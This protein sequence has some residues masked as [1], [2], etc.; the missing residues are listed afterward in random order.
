L[1]QH[2]CSMFGGVGLH[3]TTS[4]RTDPQHGVRHD[5]PW[6]VFRCSAPRPPHRAGQPLTPQ[7]PPIV[8]QWP[9]QHRDDSEVLHPSLKQFQWWGPSQDRGNPSPASVSPQLL[10]ANC[11][12]FT[13]AGN[14][15]ARSVECR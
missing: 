8:L 13:W 2:T 3:S 15:E 4:P 12:S 10:F 14:G 11:S 1:L 5:P 7:V 6:L 9:R